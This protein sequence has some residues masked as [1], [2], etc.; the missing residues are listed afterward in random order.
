MPDVTCILDLKSLLLKTR[1][2]ILFRFIQYCADPIRWRFERFVSRNWWTVPLDFCLSNCAFQKIK[3][4]WRFL[5]TCHCGSFM[6]CPSGSPEMHSFYPWE[7]RLYRFAHGKRHDKKC[8]ECYFVK[9]RPHFID[10]L[11]KKLP[12]IIR[13]I[14]KLFWNS[15]QLW[16]WF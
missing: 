2:L 3:L 10:C 15:E 6:K 1:L 13:T 5:S 8:Y 16:V 9:V 14:L 12:L 7:W 11:K 4:K